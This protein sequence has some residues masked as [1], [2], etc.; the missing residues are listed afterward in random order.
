MDKKKL[1]LVGALTSL[2]AVGAMGAQAAPSAVQ[3]VSRA[4]SYAELLDPIPNAVERLALVNNQAEPDGARLI[5]AQYG[6]GPVAHH[7]HHSHYR[8]HWRRRHYHHHHHHHHHNN[9]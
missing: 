1:G 8:R 6:Y 9:D 7:H 3:P 2:A 5:E 4:Q